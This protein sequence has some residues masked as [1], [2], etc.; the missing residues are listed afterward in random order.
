MLDRK[1]IVDAIEAHCRLLSAGDKEGWLRLWASDTMLEDPVG[2][3]VFSGRN[4]LATTFWDMI[5]KISPMKLWLERDVIVC[6]NEA[7]AILFGVVSPNSQMRKVG[8]IVD[9][10]VFN[11]EGEIASMRAFWKY[12]PDALSYITQ[13]PV[14]GKA[15]GA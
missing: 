6:G 8:P 9:H 2:M 11:E 1:T 7:I 15:V 3:D 12:D 13:R 10:F 4:E 14:D 5:E